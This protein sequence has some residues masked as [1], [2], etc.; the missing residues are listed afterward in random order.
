MIGY[1]KYMKMYPSNSSAINLIATVPTR[2]L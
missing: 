2:G 1:S